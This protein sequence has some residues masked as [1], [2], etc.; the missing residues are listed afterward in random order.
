[1]RLAAHHRTPEGL[2]AATA[3]HLPAR[4]GR[5]WSLV[6]DLH[7]DGRPAAGLS[8]GDRTLLLTAA[9]CG[10]V[11][12]TAWPKGG[13]PLAACPVPGRNAHPRHLAA[14]AVRRH[15]P[16]ADAVRHQPGHAE[17]FDHAHQLLRELCSSP[18]APGRRT[19]STHNDLPYQ[20]T[21]YLDEQARVVATPSGDSAVVVRATAIRLPY[22]ERLLRL[23]LES[24]TPQAPGKAVVGAAARRLAAAW[25]LEPTGG[26][27]DG[28]TRLTARPMHPYAPQLEITL[29]P[30]LPGHDRERVDLRLRCGVDLALLALATLR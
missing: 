9:P 18:L 10:E 7:L 4:H 30:G 11:R 25:P 13:T 23:A 16:A 21:W 14:T 3:T 5:S 26:S 22:A 19:I 15:L 1:M 17:R 12:M 20:V 27:A 8:D 2:A 29:W 24:R 28:T 6:R